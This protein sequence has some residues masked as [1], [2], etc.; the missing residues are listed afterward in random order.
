M[1]KHVRVFLGIA[2]VLLTLIPISLTAGWMKHYGREDIT[3][4]GYGVLET[5]DNGF[6]ISAHAEDEGVWVI[7]TDSVGNVQWDSCY[8]AGLPYMSS[9]CIR[10]TRDESYILTGSGFRLLKID[11]W[12]FS[13]MSS[14]IGYPYTSRWVEQASSRCYI[15]TGRRDTIH[16]VEG[17]ASQVWVFKADTLGNVI[18]ENLYGVD[19]YEIYNE[20]KCILETSDSNYMVCGFTQRDLWLAKL[21]TFGVVM[22]ENTYLVGEA[23]SMIE[24]SDGSIVMAGNEHD[25]GGVL[26][27][28]SSDGVLL[29]KK[30]FRQD[31]TFTSVTGASDGGYVIAG[32]T[33]DEFE[34]HDV[35]VAKTDNMGQ[36]LWTKI[37]GDSA[38]TEWAEHVEHTADGGYIVSGSIRWTAPEPDNYDVLL[39]KLDANGDTVTTY[40]SETAPQNES[41]FEII[42]SVGRQILIRYLSNPASS[43]PGIVIYDALGRQVDE[44]FLDG[45]GT[46]TWGEGFTPGVY[47][48]RE[49]SGEFLAVQKVI[50]IR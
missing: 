13:L 27:K 40:I 10:N 32:Y 9:N 3:E 44:L 20:G 18:W 11:L 28:T 2:L 37:Y 47:F 17:Y 5:W 45:S 31:A 43:T 19:G 16:E 24:D 36:E 23:L 15:A 39:L 33:T 30:N 22:W 8:D 50:L 35:L 34:M 21:D 46:T 38:N 49:F 4:F 29:W 12:G 14:S 48:I 6:V 26:V 1:S 25:S 42:T 41:C 7:R